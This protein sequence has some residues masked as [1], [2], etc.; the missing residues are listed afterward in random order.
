MVLFPRPPL[1]LRGD[2]ICILHSI[3]IRGFAPTAPIAPGNLIVHVRKIHFVD[4]EIRG[5]E[6]PRARRERRISS[7]GGGLMIS[8]HF[9]S[10][11]IVVPLLAFLLPPDKIV[12]LGDSGGLVD[13]VHFD[14]TLEEGVH[15]EFAAF[16]PMAEE[17]EDAL[18]PAHEL[19]EET[20]VVNVDLVDKFVE[21]VLVAGAEIDEGLHR[22]VRVG[23]DVLALGEVEDTE[24]VIGKGGEVGDGVVD[25]CGFVDADEGLV[26]DGEEVAEE[27]QGDGFFDDGE[28][29]RLI[30]L[31]GVHFEELFEVGE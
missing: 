20:V 23:G 21:I 8:G 7:G 17:L 10:R 26:E 29:H 6:R 3:F 14:G 13:L 4:A 11:L 15:V 18:E 31:A 19:A 5:A 30:P 27:L 24:H 22:L 16:G 12:D 9:L 25:V 1:P 2:R 28:H